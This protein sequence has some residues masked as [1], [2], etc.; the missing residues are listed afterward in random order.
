M[1]SGV[2]VLGQRV[3]KNPRVTINEIL[4]SLWRWKRLREAPPSLQRSTNLHLYGTAARQAP[5]LT[6]KH[7]TAIWE[8]IEIE[9][10]GFRKS[11]ITLKMIKI[12]PTARHGGGSIM[13][14][15]GNW[16]V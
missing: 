9:L 7:M 1:S 8:T 16:S 6:K 14:Q 5:V 13:L 2:K 3:T 4:G 10:F 11:H 12:I 15:L